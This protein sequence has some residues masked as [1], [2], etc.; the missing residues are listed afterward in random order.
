MQ[1]KRDKNLFHPLYP[2]LKNM[3]QATCLESLLS[4]AAIHL[5]IRVMKSSKLD[6][7][8]LQR[9]DPAAWTALLCHQTGLE[10]VLVTAVDTAV[11][12]DSPLQDTQHRTARYRLAL[13]NHSDPITLLAKRT[14]Q[15]ELR[16]YQEI[17]PHLSYL[18]PRCWLAHATTDLDGWIVIDD[19]PNDFPPHKWSPSHVESLI[20]DLADL[21]AAFWQEEALADID[22]LPHFLGDEAERYSWEDL[23]SEQPYY[24][25]EGPA[26]IL[27]E[28][29]VYNAGR[30][31]PTLLEAANGLAV[32]R[33][34]GGWPGIL[35]ESHLEVAADLL[36]DPVPMLQPL[37]DLPATLLHGRLHN[38]QW[39]ITL[40]GSRHLLN[41]QATKIGPGVCDL[42]S[43]VEEF[44]LLYRPGGQ[45]YT[46]DQ[47]P[48]SVETII[49][50]YM[51]AMSARLG[52][53]FPARTVRQAIPAARCLH[54]LTNW[55]PHFA[56]WL[57][58]MP[59]PYTWQKVNRMSDEELRGTMFEAMVGFRPYLADVFHRFL[60]A[61]YLL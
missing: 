45:L 31:A 59:S 12:T 46:R 33:A 55:F 27:S 37:L 54:V 13:A 43:F 42:V 38:Y 6:I 60:R 20:D 11:Y 49:D 2:W 29:A 41:W 39:H 28:H 7:I 40:F 61:S 1:V 34:L 10:D 26:A 22:W 47:R 21:H 51:L 23:K 18:T 4:A 30:L 52:S 9:R 32:M 8:Q 5:T 19:V 53:S 15:R 3:C 35:S 36:D 16:F 58:E 14:N 57:A 24:F 17:A 48:I 50:S 25:E 56:R 44:D